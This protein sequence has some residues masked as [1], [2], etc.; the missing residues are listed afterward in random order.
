MT[1]LPF[2]TRNITTH[3]A[4]IMHLNIFSHLRY[5]FIVD[6]LTQSSPG[7]GLIGDLMEQIVVL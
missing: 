5:S 7:A 4:S 2:F 3:S 1:I 6:K